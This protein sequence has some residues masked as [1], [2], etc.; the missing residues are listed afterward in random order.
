MRKEQEIPQSPTLISLKFDFYKSREKSKNSS[1]PQSNGA[2]T[3]RPNRVRGFR[4]ALR[5]V[6]IR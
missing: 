3:I 1:N 4:A 6:R 5:L 2:Q